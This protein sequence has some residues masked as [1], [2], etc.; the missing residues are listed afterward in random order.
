VVVVVPF[1]LFDR[2]IVG[3]RHKVSA[4]YLPTYLQDMTFRLNNRKTQYLSRDML[5]GLLAS[6]NLEHKETTMVA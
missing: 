5:I 1:S 3:V 2:C 6:D 4:K